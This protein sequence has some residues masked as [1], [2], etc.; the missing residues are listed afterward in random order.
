MKRI[1]NLFLVGAARS[2]TTSLW[3]LLQSHPK[4]FMP[5]ER[6]QKEPAFFSDLKKSRFK[7]PESYFR[8]FEGAG[9]THQWVGEASTAYLTDPDSA[10]RIFEYNPEAKIFIML[11]NPGIRAYSL[12]NWMVQEGYEYARSFAEALMLEKKRIHK[13][14]PNYYEPEYYYNYLYFLSGLYSEQ[15]KRYTALF[16]DRVLLIKFE[17]YVRDT[18]KTWADVC[19]FLNIKTVR[20]PEER[21]DHDV[22]KTRQARS[23]AAQ[24]VLRKLTKFCLVNEQA[25]KENLN[26]DGITSTPTKNVNIKK[27]AITKIILGQMDRE[28]KQLAIE[29]KI[30]VRDRLVIRHCCRQAIDG[31][32]SGIVIINQS[33]KG[34]RDALVRIGLR[35]QRPAGLAKKMLHSLLD[36]YRDDIQKLSALTGIDF[37][38]WHSQPR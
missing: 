33:T 10:R 1:P 38:G 3:R 8:L 11:R 35:R 36:G 26:T 9:E 30:G 27:Q 18:E 37:S 32:L 13:I 6:L 28:L 14:I 29:T 7:T 25:I 5:G 19:G 31:M 17:D 16:K 4:V 20:T 23:A 22:N 21:I 2:G 24:F 12:Y 34:A 15:V